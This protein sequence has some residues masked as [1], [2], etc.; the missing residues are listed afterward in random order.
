K[1]LQSA[2][3]LEFW[4]IVEPY[5]PQINQSLIG[6]NQFLMKEAA[7]KKLQ[8]KAATPSTEVKTDSKLADKLAKTDTTKSALEKQLTSANAKDS[9][10]SSLDSLRSAT[11]SPLFSLSS[12]GG[13]FLYPVKDTAQINAIFKRDEVRAL[14]PRTVGLFWD[15]KADPDVTPGIEDIK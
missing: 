13:T 8:E 14:L 10:T 9:T 12:Q 3:R 11:A 7:A 6:I 4:E 5:D 1:L 15:V 2:A